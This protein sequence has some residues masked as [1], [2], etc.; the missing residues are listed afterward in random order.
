[1]DTIIAYLTADH[2]RCDDGFAAAEEAVA[3][4][5]WE[6]ADA[7][8]AAFRDAMFRHFAMEEEVLFP[9]FEEATGNPAG[10]TQVMRSEH[11]QMREVLARMGASLEARDGDQY[12]G[13]GETLLILMQQHNIKE[14]QILYPMS[15]RALG[16][17]RDD[18]LRRMEA[19]PGGA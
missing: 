19:V 18:L 14:E 12:G 3:L 1:M 2:R 4:G 11:Q 13:L 6:A 7:G 9:A 17:V 15:D 10:P 5:A 8:F 16:S